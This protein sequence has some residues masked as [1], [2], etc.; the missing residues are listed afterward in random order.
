MLTIDIE[1]PGSKIIPR[2]NPD[3]GSLR[4]YPIPTPPLVLKALLVPI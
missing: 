2:S 3:K 4:G 1:T